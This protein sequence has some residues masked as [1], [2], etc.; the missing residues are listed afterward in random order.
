MGRRVRAGAGRKAKRSAIFPD[1]SR[2]PNPVTRPETL[3]FDFRGDREVLPQYDGNIKKFR[4][5]LKER[6][7]EEERRLCYVALTRAREVLV[8]SAAYWYEGPAR[9]V[10]AERVLQRDRLARSLRGAPAC[11]RSAPSPT[12]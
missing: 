2:Q 5:T 9:P 3:P 8:C 12:R 7:L 10:R 11:G 1:V 6:G 4:E